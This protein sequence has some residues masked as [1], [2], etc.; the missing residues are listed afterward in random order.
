[1]DEFAS[2]RRGFLKGIGSLAAFAAFT[3]GAGLH[4]ASASVRSEEE[5]KGV[6][7][8]RD[9]G[10]KGDGKTDDT[11]A[12][13]KAIDAA[14]EMG[15][16]IVFIPRGDYLI[17]GTLEVREHV[18]LEGVF[19]GP[20]YGSQNRGS[21][22]LAIAGKEQL[23]GT[24]FITLRQNATLH[25]LTIFYPAQIQKD[26]PIPYP[27]TVRGIGD[28]CTLVDVLLVNP[29]QG[30][31]FGTFPAGRHFIRNVGMQA[32]YRGLYIDQC[33]DIGRVENLHIWPFWEVWQTPLKG[34]TEREG[35]AFI[36]GRTD[37]EYMSNCFCI[38]YKI[39]FQFIRTQAGSPNVVLTQCGSDVGPV[40]VRVE[41]VQEHAGISFVNGQ[42][43]AGV[44]IEQTNT[45]PVKFTAC[46]FWG[47]ETT[48][49]HAVL[50]GKGHTFF[51]GCHFNGWDR[52]KTGAPCIDA[53]RGGL[54]VVGCDFMD[55]GKT[56]IHL[57]ADIDAALITGNRLR[58]QE[59]IL[60]EAGEKAQA[61][62]NVV[63]P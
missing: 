35:I 22:L 11:V 7:S 45:G 57:G 23:D 39:G 13:Q 55:R 46:G 33:Y 31:D 3:E 53:R 44:E 17:G 51:N 47:V 20:T 62:M 38:G 37:W 10:A 60:N 18:V 28:N 16:N 56:H 63:T 34:F 48:Q 26:P 42:F 4:V 24:P 25:G 52:Q 14:H 19:R 15:G 43:M 40:A 6:L 2:L 58:G 29:Y 50:K 59:G 1:M 8:V 32:L 21:T 36:I 54:T 41:S 12:F 27:W 61:G 49:S 30:I 5:P 9:F